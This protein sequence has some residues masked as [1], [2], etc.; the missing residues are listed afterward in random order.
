MIKIAA[1]YIA[2]ALFLFLSKNLPRLQFVGLEDRPMRY[3]AASDPYLDLLHHI[4]LG[5][6]LALFKEVTSDLNQVAMHRKYFLNLAFPIVAHGMI[7]QF[8]LN[9]TAIGA[10]DNYSRF[11]CWQLEDSL[12]SAAVVK[13]TVGTAI[14]FLG[15]VDSFSVSVGPAGLHGG[16][17]VAPQPQ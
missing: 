15:T 14:A 3:I 17:H 1:K 11:E 10:H 9:V 4:Y 16:L 5:H 12:F 6:I 7:P 8:K 2:S 13:G